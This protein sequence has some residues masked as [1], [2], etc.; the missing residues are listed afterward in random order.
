VRLTD[1]LR[2]NSF[3]TGLLFIGLF[4]FASVILFG[5]I[6]FETV[7]YLSR[8]SEYWLDH[9]IAGRVH[10]TQAE[11][12]FHLNS[13]IAIDPGEHR[14]FALYDTKGRIVAG[15]MT[16]QPKPP[17]FDVPFHFAGVNSE[18]KQITYQ[19]MAHAL[20]D[21]QVL[22]VG[23]DVDEAEDF[24]ELIIHALVI[25]TGVMLVVGLAGAVV[26]GRVA[27][28]HIDAMR[29]AIEQIVA[30]HLSERLPVGRGSG[31][32]DRLAI[33]VNAMLDELE[34]MVGEVKGVCDNLAHDMRTPLG[35]LLAGLE[36]ARRRDSDKEGLRNAIDAA[37]GEIKDILR[38]FA[39]LLRISEIED[40]VRRAGF[41]RLDLVQ[42]ATDAVEYHQPAADVR[43]ISFDLDLP[44]TAPFTGDPS[45]L[46]EAIANL[47]DNA[48]K[49]VGDQGHI[50]LA[51]T[52]GHDGPTI[53]VADD[54][55]GIPAAERQA[56]LG[57]FQ[58]GE[59]SRSL[60]G[61]GLGL[62]LVAAIARL[63]GLSIEI[64]D[65]VKGCA[66]TLESKAGIR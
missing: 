32:L 23:Q 52:V 35:R 46:F 26:L 30:G 5:V 66:V 64:A 10:T 53:R 3:R 16:G 2:T 59:A 50:E 36:R 44:S 57:R 7:N 42:V 8:Q 51:V 56:V 13:R 63:H 49:F 55:P 29:L 19:A 41:E 37:I 18:G 24:S 61:N 6:Y 60:P 21:G 27:A 65:T 12:I 38:I 48:I 11:R 34:R 31:D 28:R 62:P 15:Y 14:P 45:L 58:R 40:G 20:D 9:E 25:G 54:G 39:A 4:G 47:L 22:I 33:V 1:L 43:G 17:A